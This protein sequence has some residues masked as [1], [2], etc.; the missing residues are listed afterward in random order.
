MDTRTTL[1]KRTNT[2]KK[3]KRRNWVHAFNRGEICTG[4]QMD[5]VKDK[6]SR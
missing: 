5:M 1:K 6:A 2:D 3:E 4:N